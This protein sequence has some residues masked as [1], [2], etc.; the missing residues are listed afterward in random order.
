MLIVSLRE[1]LNKYHVEVGERRPDRS[2]VPVTGTFETTS[3][4]S[5]PAVDP[6]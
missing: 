4:R 6:V 5:T 2:N 3:A 1:E